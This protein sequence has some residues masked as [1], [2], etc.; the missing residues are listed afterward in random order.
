MATLEIREGFVRAVEAIYGAAAAPD[1]WPA[2]LQTIADCFSDVGAILIYG[3]DDGSFGVVASP[4]LQAAVTEYMRD[5]THRDIRALRS[6]ERGYFIGSDV[7]TDRDVVT[8]DELK[9]D[10]FYSEFL[11]SHGLA[12]F[13]AA[14]VSP[15]PHVEVALSIQRARGRPVYSESELDTVRRLG[16]HVEKSLRLSMRLMNAELIN[17]GLSEALGRIA[18]GVFA[19][20]SLKRIVFAN[21]FGKKLIGDGIE[22]AEERLAF[23]PANDR[24]AIDMVVRQA[25]A[26]TPEALMA[27]PKPIL[28]HRRRSSRPLALYVLPIAMSMTATQQFLT[29]ARAIVLLIDPEAAGPPEPALVRDLLQLT[30][31][32]A[33]IASLVGSGLPPREAA[34]KLG[35]SEE[36]ARSALKRVFGKV[37]VSR[38]SELAALMTRLVLR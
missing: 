31:G 8:E 9:T 16:P 21:P 28:I 20:D 35:I 3:R 13:A 34:A 38:Q 17:M 30:L 11:A 6:R 2:T 32:E 33:R 19:I 23:G 5:W 24:A 12:Y 27:E 7:I 37:G 10:P 4:R 26:G 36:T 29:H 15:D 1:H 14:M 18:V 22:I 25:I